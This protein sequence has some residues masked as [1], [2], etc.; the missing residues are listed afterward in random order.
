MT[1]ALIIIAIAELIG[2]TVTIF[3][4]VMW[5]YFNKK[6]DKRRDAQDRVVELLQK[7]KP[8]QLFSNEC[9]R[10]IHTDSLCVPSDYGK[11]KDNYCDHFK[12]VFEENEE[13]KSKIRFLQYAGD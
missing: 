6:E 4:T 12:S 5:L 13:L 8:K 11:D 3:N 10:C 9:V 7:E 2:V 1:K